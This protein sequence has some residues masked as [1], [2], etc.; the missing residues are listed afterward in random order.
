MSINNDRRDTLQRTPKYVESRG[1]ECML[2]A[3]YSVAKVGEPKPQR[4]NAQGSGGFDPV[5]AH[6]MK[7]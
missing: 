1:A 4:A 3:L 7:I 5:C 6:C 2:P